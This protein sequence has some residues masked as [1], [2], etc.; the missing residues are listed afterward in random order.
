LD[1]GPEDEKEDGVQ[2][3]VAAVLPPILILLLLPVTAEVVV[4]AGLLAW[5]GPGSTDC[6]VSLSPAQPPPLAV[7]AAADVEEVLFRRR[8]GIFVF[9]Q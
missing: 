8:E 9:K 2:V 7:A 1:A 4:L 3:A 6:E 5:P